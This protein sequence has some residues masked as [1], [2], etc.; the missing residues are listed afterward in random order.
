MNVQ[1]IREPNGTITVQAGRWGVNMV[2]DISRQQLRA[3][4]A[5]LRSAVGI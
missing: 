3:A 2:R 4:F 1:R 5:M